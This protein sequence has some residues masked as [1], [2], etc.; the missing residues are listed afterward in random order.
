MKNRILRLK[1]V[2]DLVG[3]SR[4]TIYLKMKLGEF[5]KSIEISQRCIGWTQSSIEEWIEDK[6]KK[7]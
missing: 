2:M 5:P 3:L 6:I 4:S 7:S 1:E